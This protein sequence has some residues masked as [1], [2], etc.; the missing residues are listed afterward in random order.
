MISQIDLNQIT[1]LVA[2]SASVSGTSFNL[3]VSINSN[4]KTVSIDVSTNVGNPL[5]ESVF[6]YQELD[7]T[8]KLLTEQLT[9][10]SN[11]IKELYHQ[12]NHQLAEVA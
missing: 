8:S 9:E 3:S 1:N 7:F 2:F 11:K 6:F 4:E 5:K 12:H 10:V